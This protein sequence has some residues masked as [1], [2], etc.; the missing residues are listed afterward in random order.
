M[1]D[2]FM[3]EIQEESSALEE[4]ER[5]VSEASGGNVAVEAADEMIRAN[6][7]AQAI[8]VETLKETVRAYQQQID[9]LKALYA[10]NSALVESM[11]Q[12]NVETTKGVQDVMKA[13]ADALSENSH[14]LE[15]VDFARM[16][17][18]LKGA[19]EASGTRI[20]ESVAE[21]QK[22]IEDLLQ[23]SDD[24]AHKENVRVYRNV[25]A[26]TEQLLTKQT[27]ELKMQIDELKKPQK[28]KISWIQILILLLAAAAVV[29]EVLQ[30]AGIF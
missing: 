10:R 20:L 4:L 22:K 9:E 28:P 18:E 1:S 17:E 7:E 3:Q 24:F 29:L 16:Q 12:M 19:S 5:R 25:Q 14:A 26:A 13:S 30:I 15:G 11:R 8:E 27:E 21:S 23:Q 6:G 2:Q